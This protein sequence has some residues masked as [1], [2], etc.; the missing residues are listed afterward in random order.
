[1]AFKLSFRPKVLR[2]SVRQCLK[3]LEQAGAGVGK[4]PGRWFHCAMEVDG[5]VSG[6]DVWDSI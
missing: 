1:M 4:V 6:F 2:G 5:A 3:R